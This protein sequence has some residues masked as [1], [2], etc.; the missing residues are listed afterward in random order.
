VRINLNASTFFL[1]NNLQKHSLAATKTVARLSSGRYSA[2]DQPNYLSRINRLE[3]NI[4]SRQVSQ[5]NIQEGI[6]L[7]QTAKESLGYTND[8]VQRLRELA[9]QYQNGSLSETDK[10][11]I[12][13]EAKMLTNEIV[14][15][16]ERT[17][18]NGMNLFDKEMYR[19]QT[20]INI[21]DVYYVHMPVITT[22]RKQELKVT[23]TNVATV[24]AGFM[25]Y[26]GHAAEKSLEKS[27]YTNEIVIE[28]ITGEAIPQYKIPAPIISVPD[29]QG[30]TGYK[31][32]YDDNG[33]LIYDGYLK[34]G[35]FD[36]YGR[37]YD[38][39]KIIYEGDWSNGLYNGY[40]T[41][42][43]NSGK[44]VYQGDIKNG[45]P[46][47]WGTV[48]GTN[49][50]VMYQGG[51]ENGYR[52]GW[53]T[54][55]DKDGKYLESK[56]Y[57]DATVA[58]E[59]E[60]SQNGDTTVPGTEPPNGGSGNT[61]TEPPNEGSGN[62]GTEP[63]NEGSGNTGTEPP[64]EGSGNTGTEPPNEG[65]G[66]TG[67]EPPNEGSG[68]A[69]T[70]PPN[71]GNGSATSPNDKF[72]LYDF[73]EMDIEEVLNESFLDH[74]VKEI[75]AARVNLEVS[76]YILE[77]R[78][79]S[80]ATEQLIEEEALSKIRDVDVAKETMNLVKQQLLQEINVQLLH[81]FGDDHRQLI[82]SLLR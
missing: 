34:D 59:S 27:N 29:Q 44:K 65:S 76:Q 54:T 82:L 41:V 12:Q 19:I 6:T 57:A 68:N 77:R 4:R 30:Y 25:L 63:P 71:N 48:Y 22:P 78:F 50:K 53:G 24:K 74:V 18:F 69:G 47:G 73:S 37:L 8:I 3:T 80:G 64:N 75:D 58:R 79:D 52:Q 31:K 40:G 9:V 33:D 11:K 1:L 17:K 51:L 60:G 32:I 35:K 56:Y 81:Q 45:T 66:N 26:S 5:Q 42:Y 7:I 39:N 36:G 49:G 20:G 10:L 13:E 72:S 55:Y 43:D 38:K 28:E 67:T 2:L 70:E 15:K 16:L 62:T 21:E 14:S 61:G 46:H 23:N